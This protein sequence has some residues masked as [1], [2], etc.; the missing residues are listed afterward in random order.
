MFPPVNIAS[1]ATPALTTAGGTDAVNSWTATLSRASYGNGMYQV[2]Q[3]SSSSGNAAPA[4]WLFVRTDSADYGGAHW[5]PGNYISGRFDGSK[6]TAQYT[7]D[8]MYFGD[9]VHMQ[10]PAPIVVTRCSFKARPGF[11]SRTPKIFRIYG[12]SDGASWELVHDQASA[13]PYSNSIGTFNVSSLPTCLYIGLV[14]SELTGPESILNFMQWDI[15]GKVHARSLP[16]WL[17][18]SVFIIIVDMEQPSWVAC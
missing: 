1:S 9:W 17:Q 18:M 13:L 3:S 6:S 12:S 2:T 10:L 7:L 16:A 15:F 14:V 4:W 8:G 11:L 5:K